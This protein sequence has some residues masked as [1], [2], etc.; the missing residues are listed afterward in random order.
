MKFCFLLILIALITF[1]FPSY[2]QLTT[3]EKEE[4]QK[5]VYYLCEKMMQCIRLRKDYFNAE[6]DWV[7]TCKDIFNKNAII[8][9]FKISY[10]S[11][12]TLSNEEILIKANYVNDTWMNFNCL[13]SS[14]E[15]YVKITRCFSKLLQ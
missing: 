14:E 9:Y 3:S 5:E 2:S 13:F 1:T 7:K 11:E 15:L 12:I 4:I 8:V 10:E 6:V